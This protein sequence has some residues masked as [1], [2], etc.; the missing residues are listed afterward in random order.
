VRL[1]G[2]D[3]PEKNQAFGQNAKQFTS[4]MIFG[5]TVTVI[6]SCKDRYGRVLGDVILEDGS[7]LNKKLIINGFAWWYKQYAP[8]DEL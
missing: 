1:N 8:N 4:D 2:V 3:C 5:K 6:S 7:S